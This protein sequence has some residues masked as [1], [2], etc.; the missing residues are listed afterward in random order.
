MQSASK[1][2]AASELIAERTETMI[3][4]RNRQSPYLID[5]AMDILVL[6]RSSGR[7]PNRRHLRA[8]IG[9]AAQEEPRRGFDMRQHVFPSFA[10]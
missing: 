4:S 3:A 6:R 10:F 5:G 1:G 2:V 8:D 7:L 9:I